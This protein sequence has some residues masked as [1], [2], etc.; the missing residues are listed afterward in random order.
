MSLNKITYYT[1]LSFSFV[2]V[3][4]FLYKGNDSKYESLKHFESDFNF[5][6]EYEGEQKINR[7]APYFRMAPISLQENNTSTSTLISTQAI[8]EQM[9]AAAKAALSVSSN[10]SV[11]KS[12]VTA[13]AVV[14]ST[15]SYFN[16][17]K[18]R[19][20]TLSPKDYYAIQKKREE[21]ERIKM[22]RD[23]KLSIKKNQNMPKLHLQG[24]VGKSAII[25]GEMLNEGQTYK[26]FKLIKVGYDYVIG[27]FNGKKYRIKIE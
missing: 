1:L 23:K 18:D 11:S 7:F 14:S 2:L 16:P 13:L 10:T 17:M 9:E 6:K 26:G 24:I 21:I 19:D 3:S 12:S 15:M 27:S 5:P 8:V 20:P 25:N 22:E 4:F